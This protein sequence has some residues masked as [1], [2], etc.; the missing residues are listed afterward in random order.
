M[1]TRWL[2][3]IVSVTLGVALGISAGAWGLGELLQSFEHQDG[4]RLATFSPDGQWVA[5]GAVSGPG[6]IWSPTSGAQRYLVSA[7]DVRNMGF[8]YD[9]S[10]VV[11]AVSSSAFLWN[12]RTG[13]LVSELSDFSV[14]GLAMSPTSP[15]ALV[16]STYDNK[17]ELY[18]MVNGE[19]AQAFPRDGEQLQMGVFSPDGT[20]VLTG[21]DISRSSTVGILWDATTYTE[22][23]RFSSTGQVMTC[24]GFTPDGQQAM[25]CSYDNSVVFFDIATGE[26]VGALSGN[27]TRVY[28]YRFSPDG[29]KVATWGYAE[30]PGQPVVGTLWDTSTGTALRQF[31]NTAAF[32]P[33]GSYLV[34]GS[35]QTALLLDASTLATVYTFTEITTGLGCA[36]FSPDSN[37]LVLGCGDK[38]LSVYYVGAGQ[39]PV[40]CSDLL[41]DATCGEG[42]LLIAGMP[43]LSPTVQQHFDT[44]GWQTWADIDMEKFDLFLAGD[45]VTVG[46]GLPDRYQ[47]ALVQYVLDSPGVPDHD[48]IVQEFQENLALLRQDAD[49]LSQNAVGDYMALKSYDELFAAMLG[50]S[51]EMQAAV[52]AFVKVS[53]DGTTGLPHIADYHVFGLGSG[54]KTAAEPYSAEGDLDHDGFTNVDEYQQVAAFGGGP[55]MFASLA[56]DQY[57]IWA[58]NPSVPTLGQVASIV[59]MGLLSFAG[60]RATR[61]RLR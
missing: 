49:W 22:I 54:G 18:S 60:Y 17:V 21:G 59:L 38:T 47:V 45:P 35:D 16:S 34:V 2:N 42:T 48:R 37:R 56:F 24:V 20:K 27:S 6:K 23:R 57:N 7:G 52:N 29:S 10:R 19:L 33:N 9:G 53:A 43:N 13:A 12:M 5:S 15:V 31:T 25:L 41:N 14:T 11:A 30:G 28:S 58:G 36:A 50:F 1:S 39:P 55:D 4:I 44:L 61:S 8:S 26:Q 40:Y 46:D 32:S 3:C 51:A